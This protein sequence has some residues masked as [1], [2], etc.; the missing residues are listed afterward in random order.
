[1][2][3]PFVAPQGA[4]G[5]PQLGRPADAVLVRHWD[6]NEPNIPFVMEIADDRLRCSN[7]TVDVAPEDG[8]T[9]DI[10][11]VSFEIGTL[12]GSKTHTQIAHVRDNN[13]VVAFS[14]I[15]QGDSHLLRLEPNSQLL[16]TTLPTGERAYRI[17]DAAEGH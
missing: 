15:K 11:S 17:V 13:G 10:F 9:D 12:P 2:N 16:P 8:E 7:M 4:S 14:I 6:E 3:Q 1:M 5:Q